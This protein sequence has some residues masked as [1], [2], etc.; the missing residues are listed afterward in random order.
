[1]CWCWPTTG[2][3]SFNASTLSWQVPGVLAAKKVAPCRI[4]RIQYHL[5][6]IESTAANLAR[7]FAEF[8]A[9]VE[10]GETIRIRDHGRM[11]A[12]MV[13]DCDFMLGSQA[14]A[15]FKN[16]RADSEAANAIAG[17]LRKL[18]LEA[19]NALDH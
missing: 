15:L 19:E 6:M 3:L 11:V 17:E 13:P 8:L 4:A 2:L 9:K 18:A 16:H 10:R 7:H 12:R 5:T 1:M 14:A